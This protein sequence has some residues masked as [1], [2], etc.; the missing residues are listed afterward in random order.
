MNDKRPAVPAGYHLE[1]A[2]YLRCSVCKREGVAEPR[3]EVAI[4]RHGLVVVCIIHNREVAA[5]GL[6]EIAGMMAEAAERN[7]RDRITK[8]GDA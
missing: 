5:I 3:V 1:N 4:A 7:V 6:A 8:G 2:C